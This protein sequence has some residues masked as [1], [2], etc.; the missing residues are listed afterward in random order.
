MYGIGKLRVQQLLQR[1]IDLSSSEDK[2]FSL[3]FPSLTSIMTHMPFP[4][5]FSL[6]SGCEAHG[7]LRTVT[8][9]FSVNVKDVSFVAITIAE[10][11]RENCS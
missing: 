4:Y 3:K 6:Q 2:V 8:K 9:Q 10:P 5:M 1:L 11:F 7:S